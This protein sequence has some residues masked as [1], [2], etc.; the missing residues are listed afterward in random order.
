ML[1]LISGCQTY[2]DAYDRNLP[3]HTPAVGSIIELHQPLSVYPGYSRSFIQFGKALKAN[4]VNHRYP[5]CQFR[6]YEPASA[7]DSE[8]IINADRFVVIQ[9][10]KR[11]ENIASNPPMLASSIL[12]LDMLDDDPSDQYLSSIMRIQSETQP[13]VFE[14]KCSIFTEPR[15]YNYATIPQMQQTLGSLVT[16]NVVDN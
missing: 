8:R 1:A 9:S 10:N 3:T 15:I 13:Q 2:S 5:W 14:F 16:I 7:L 4:E 12:L 11:M 6:L